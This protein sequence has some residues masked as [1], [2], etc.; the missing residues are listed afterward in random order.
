MCAQ[1]AHA[2]VGSILKVLV[3]ETNL[4]IEYYNSKHYQ[5]ELT[6]NELLWLAQGM[7]KIVVGVPTK[8]ALE[9]IIKDA[10]SLEVT[11]CPVID[12][13]LTEFEG[14]T[15]TCVALGPDEDSKLSLL[16]GNLKLL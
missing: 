16:T 6:R 13:G 3:E 2:S 14:P 7:K 15:L 4:G 9:Q 12:A 5:V 11:C 1:A 10:R 8:E